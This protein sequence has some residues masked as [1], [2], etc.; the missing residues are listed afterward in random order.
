MN[1]RN[2]VGAAALAIAVVPSLASSAYA[3]PMAI[4]SIVAQDHSMRSSKLIG[5]DVYDEKGA[6]IGKIEDILVKGSASEPLAVL[7]VGSF[8]G[9]GDKMVAVPMSHIRLKSDKAS[10]EATK[11]EMAVMP[12]WAFTGLSSGGG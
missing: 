2:I 1:I 6:R 5:M 10:M 4:S 12:V 3:Q 9:G 7:S 8:V 11:T